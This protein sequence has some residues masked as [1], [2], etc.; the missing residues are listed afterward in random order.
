[1][2]WFAWS[3]RAAQQLAG[4][5]PLDE[6]T[7][8]ASRKTQVNRSTGTQAQNAGATQ[9][10]RR[11]LWREGMGGVS[12]RD[13]SSD[14]HLQFLPKHW[15]IAA[16]ACIQNINIIS[17]REEPQMLVYAKDTTQNAGA[18][19]RDGQRLWSEG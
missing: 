6:A 2:G 3:S 19:Q 17:C 7:V 10:D 15:C 5:P 12:G 16:A 8:K 4:L 13:P 9:R 11:R 14:Q 18:T 1:M